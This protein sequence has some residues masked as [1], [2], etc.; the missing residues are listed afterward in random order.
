M[1][2]NMTHNL[3]YA[4]L[5]FASIF[6]GLTIG[7]QAMTSPSSSVVKVFEMRA[8]VKSDCTG[9]VTVFKTAS[10]TAVDLVGRPTFG[11]GTI[12][13]GTYHCLMFHIDDLI[14]VV[15]QATTGVC[16]AGSP[17]TMD[18]FSD[19]VNDVSITPE[20]TTIHATANT[21]DDPWVYF[22]DSTQALATNNCFEPNT[23]GC[24][25]SGPCPLTALTLNSDQTHRLFIDFDN[26]VDGSGSVCTVLLP[27]GMPQ[28]IMSIQ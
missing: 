14:T 23:S 2:N 4:I 26:R 7:A 11:S 25:C 1:K 20:G 12:A 17:V 15:P 13:D 16:T 19:P 28:S 8:S 18:I 6:L 27:P 9:A 22:S 24:A 5:V 21:E 10:P 3:M